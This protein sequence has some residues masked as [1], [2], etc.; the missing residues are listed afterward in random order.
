MS[1]RQ[2]LDEGSII[3]FGPGNRPTY[4]GGFR[5]NAWAEANALVVEDGWGVVESTRT[6]TRYFVRLREDGKTVGRWGLQC[7]VVE[8][9]EVATVVLGEGEQASIWGVP[10]GPAKLGNTRCF[11]RPENVLVAI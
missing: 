6:G 5:N 3:A 8:L 7:P 11:T 4:L 1:A 2:L 9:F 10:G